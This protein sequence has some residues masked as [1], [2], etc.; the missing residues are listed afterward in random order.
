MD[1]LNSLQANDC[2]GNLNKHVNCS[3][4]NVPIS[5]VKYRK[6]GTVCKVCYNNHVLAYYKKKFCPNS[7]KSNV[8]TQTDFSDKQDFSSKYDRSIKRDKSRKHEKSNEQDESSKQ[9]I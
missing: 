4:C 6:C 7:S 8:S 2:Y 5:H 1:D 9:D 3:K